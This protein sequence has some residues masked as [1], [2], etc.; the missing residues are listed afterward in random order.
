MRSTWAATRVT[1][2]ARWMATVVMVLAV[3]GCASVTRGSGTADGEPSTPGTPVVRTERDLPELPLD[4]YEFSRRDYGRQEAA[5]RR[6][7]QRCMRSHGFADFP[8]RWRERPTTMADTHV[9]TVYSTTLYGTLDLGEARRSGYGV[10]RDAP[11]ERD[12]EQ[13]KGRLITRDEYAVLRGEP[14]GTAASRKGGFKANGRAVPS[15]GCAQWAERRLWADVKD[16]TRMAGYV[17]NRQAA[18][19]KAVAQDGR[20]RRALKAWADCVVDKGYKRYASPAAAFRDKAWGRDGRGR[21]GRTPRERGTAVA[22]IECKRTHNTVGVWSAVTA[23]KQRRDLAR[24]WS[25]YEAVRA[26]QDRVRAVVRRVLGG[27]GPASG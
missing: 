22:D 11:R 21:T 9:L 16:E 5:V 1:R 12:K 3:A 4:R 18:L 13:Q 27:K 14:S 19:D 15:G 24:H 7:T 17:V 8:S 20:I 6:L 10:V 23:E 26:D 25:A 2:W